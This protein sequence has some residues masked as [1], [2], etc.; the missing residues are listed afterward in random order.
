MAQSERS[1]AS[2]KLSTDQPT[3]LSFADLY[4]WII[5]QFPRP[6]GIGMCGAVRPPIPKHTWYPAVIIRQEQ[7]VFIHGQVDREFKSPDAAAK[8][9]DSNNGK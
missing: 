1:I 6:K 5:W 3:E 9:L 4:T 8:W 7:R 2:V